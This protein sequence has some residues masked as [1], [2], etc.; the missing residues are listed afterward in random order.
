MTFNS[1]KVG[2]EGYNKLSLFNSSELY[3]LNS[4]VKSVCEKGKVVA[5]IDCYFDN[6]SNTLLI[7]AFETLQ[8]NTGVGK[9]IISYLKN[10]QDVKSIIVQPLKNS[11]PFWEKMQFVRLSECDWIWKK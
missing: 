5:F 3:L 11:I 2:D 7:T 8:K 6:S 9:R 10:F 4:E 1:Y